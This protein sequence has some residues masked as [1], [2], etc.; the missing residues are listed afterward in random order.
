MSGNQPSSGEA[1]FPKHLL[2]LGALVLLGSG[3][4]GPP[5]KH[6]IERDLPSRG[7]L[8]CPSYLGWNAAEVQHV[9]LW[10]SGSGV[11]SS[12][13]VHPSIEHALEVSPVAYLTLD[14]PGIRAPFE[15]PAAL[16]VD[17]AVLEQYTQGHMLE[18]AR[19]AMTW[20]EEQFGDKVQFHLRGHSEGSLIALFLYEQLLAQEPEL[21]ARV[22]SLVLSGLGLEPF[23]ELI[24]RQ[25]NALPPEPGRAHRA[26]LQS[27]DWAQLET[28]WG[29]SCKYLEDA[30]AR[31]SGRAVFESLAPRAPAAR[32]FVF[33]GNEDAQT[34]ARY[35]RELEAWNTE[36]GHLDLTFRYYPGIHVGAPAEVKRELSNLLVRL[37]A[38]RAAP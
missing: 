11:F 31:P 35:T 9:F 1:R 7:G 21:A 22:S 30:Y 6:L 33:Q 16:R 14:K 27:C 2:A 24:E 5:L 37:T 38:P 26:A 29:I 12:A 28:Q 15:D 23:R 10:M 36:L 18:C 4:A 3:C 34:P 8:T 25:L 32:F 20:S 13:F 19:Q 17:H